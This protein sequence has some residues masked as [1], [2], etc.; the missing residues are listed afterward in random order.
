MTDDKEN[1]TLSHKFHL[2]EP[3]GWICYMF[4][5]R[6][7]Q[8]GNIQW[9]PPKE[10]VPNWLARFCMEIFFDCKWVKVKEDE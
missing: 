8:S 1:L 9:R 10:S 5:S 4:G 6:P 3:S 7:G 2:P